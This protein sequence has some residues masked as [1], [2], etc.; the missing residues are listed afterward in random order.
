MG[1]RQVAIIKR[2]IM[3]KWRRV[4]RTSIAPRI[5]RD[6]LTALQDALRRDDVRLI[7]GS[8]CSPPALDSLRDCEVNAACAIGFC[9]WQGDG[10]A[11]VGEIED[12]FQQI[13]DAA[14]LDFDEP[15]VCRYFLHWFDDV[16]RSEMRRE[17]LGEVTLALQGH[18][19]TA[20]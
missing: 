1:D 19:P 20:A 13:C 8:I 17:L 11:N 6:G 16:P 2:F 10:L 15:A 5:S 14:D 3:E 7:Q 18:L 12:Y 4:W 9:G